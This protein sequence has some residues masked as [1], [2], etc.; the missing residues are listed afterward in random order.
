MHLHRYR[1]VDVEHARYA[2]SK[3]PVT[4]V[5][6]VCRCG[7]PKFKELKGTFT[8]EELRGKQR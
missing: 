6:K 3:V 2:S 1:V 7:K 4:F 5:S 8:A